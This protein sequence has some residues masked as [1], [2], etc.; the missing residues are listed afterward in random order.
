VSAPAFTPCAGFPGYEVSRDGR[1]R[2]VASN[3]RGYGLR[4]LVQQPNDD[5]YPSVRLTVGNKQ[6][7]HIA[8]HRL[9]ADAFLPPQPEGTDQLR[10]LDGSRTNNRDDNLCWGTAADNAADRSAHGRTATITPEKREKMNVGIRAYFARR[11]GGRN[12]AA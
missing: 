1:V 6:R 7:R 8:V 4:E 2:S 11:A 3:W 10:H 5:G 9:V 12:V